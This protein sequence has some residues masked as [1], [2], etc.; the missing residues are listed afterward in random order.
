[1]NPLKNWITHN[2]LLKLLSFAFATTLWVAVAS[3]TSSEIGLDVPL[4]YHNLPAQLEITGDAANT[5]EV[6]LRGAANVVKD[7]TPKQ[8]STT[9]DLSNAGP[10]DRTIM[11]TAQNVQAPFGTEVIRINPSQ[12]R[13]SLEQT[14]SK[15]V[16]VA[17][18]TQGQPADGFEVGKV[19]VSPG[20]VR[21]QGPESRLRSVTSVS[22]API[23][24]NDKRTS[25]QQ[26]VGLE[27][28]DPQLRL[29]D[30]PK[31]DVRIEI[32]KTSR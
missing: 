25:L 27:L 7:I 23:S 8:V 13:I 32:R 15:T 9:V 11:L 26:S 4:E 31:V 28:P 12:V 30:Q 29:Q 3:E 19:M 5:V 16:P 18:T 22:T 14:V 20:R 10:G 1:M 2:W 6:R 17:P 21:I 24:V